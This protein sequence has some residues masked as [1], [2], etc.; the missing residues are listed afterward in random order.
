MVGLA[1]PYDTPV[2]WILL[3]HT[4]PYFSVL[5]TDSHS[6]GLGIDEILSLWILLIDSASY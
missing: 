4:L 5:K 3:G 6:L 2:K 1:V